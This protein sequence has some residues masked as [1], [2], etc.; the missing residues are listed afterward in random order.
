VMYCNGAEGDQSATPRG[1]ETRWERAERYGIELADEVMRV[2]AGIRTSGGVTFAAH[3]QPVKLPG[4]VWHPDFMKTGGA[5]YGMTPA[6][7]A[8][9]LER[10]APPTTHTT[11]LRVGDVVVVGVPGEL[12]AEMGLRLKRDVAAATGAKS[13]IIG[14]LADEW[15]SYMLSP[16]EY[17]KGGYEASVSLY[18][19]DLAP[20]VIGA[21]TEG[22][23]R[24]RR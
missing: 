14:G 22:A 5:E 24:V 10:L 20:T 1:G 2:W 23:R 9:L 12:T 7:A 17:R 4:R 16:E 15:V 11:A 8:I 13:V 19:P 3:T 6:T 21:A 18:G